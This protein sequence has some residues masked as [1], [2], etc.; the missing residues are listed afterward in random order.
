MK[1]LKQTLDAVEIDTKVNQNGQ[2]QSKVIGQIVVLVE[3]FL[4]YEHE[5]ELFVDE[6]DSHIS[7][8]EELVSSTK[9]DKLVNYFYF[10][11]ILI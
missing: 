3:E 9:L 1:S 4:K 5:C 7:N 6:L 2:G 11:I 8:M 10:F